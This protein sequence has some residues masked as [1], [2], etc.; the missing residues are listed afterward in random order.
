[1][2]I[3]EETISKQERNEPSMFKRLKNTKY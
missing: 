2:F 1:M 3:Q